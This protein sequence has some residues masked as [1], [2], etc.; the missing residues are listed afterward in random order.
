MSFVDLIYIISIINV[1][2]TD[3]TM[4]YILSFLVKH[5]AKICINQLLSEEI[6]NRSLMFLED[7]LTKLVDVDY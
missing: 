4:S 3:M 7:I 1:N 5:I 6:F 2:I